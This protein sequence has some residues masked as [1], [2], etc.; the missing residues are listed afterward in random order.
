MICVYIVLLVVVG[1]ILF[2]VVID[3]PIKYISFMSCVYIVIVRRRWQSIYVLCYEGYIYIYIYMKFNECTFG[4]CSVLATGTNVAESLFSK[5][6][7]K[8]NE[9]SVVCVH[10]DVL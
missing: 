1:K 5:E 10:F 9:Y 2:R 4:F 6:A 7:I 8:V 3:V